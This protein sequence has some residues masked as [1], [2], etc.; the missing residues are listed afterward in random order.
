MGSGATGSRG[1]SFLD[2]SQPTSSFFYWQK[3]DTR[4]HEENPLS[5][6]FKRAKKDRQAVHVRKLASVRHGMVREE[7][8]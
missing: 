7:D 6:E 2:L 3:Q 5:V 8:G 1:I 4:D